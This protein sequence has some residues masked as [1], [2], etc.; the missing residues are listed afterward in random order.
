MAIMAA[1]WPPWPA[2]SGSARYSLF[3]SEP[4]SRAWLLWNGNWPPD[5]LDDRGLLR[6]TAPTFTLK[7]GLY[8][9][10]MMFDVVSWEANRT[11]APYL[12]AKD[13]NLKGNL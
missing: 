11:S 9:V 2:H 13:S 6:W 7:C 4:P 5:D 10:L 8:G 1:S 12:H 3:V